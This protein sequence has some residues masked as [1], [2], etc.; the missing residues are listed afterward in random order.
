MQIQLGSDYTLIWRGVTVWL[1]TDGRLWIDLETLN[2][3]DAAQI[4]TIATIKTYRQAIA[5]SYRLAEMSNDCDMAVE[6]L[7][8]YSGGT[9][10]HSVRDFLNRYKDADGVRDFVLS[11]LDL[12]W[13]EV[14]WELPPDA[15]SLADRIVDTVKKLRKYQRMWEMQEVAEKYA[16]EHRGFVYLFKLSTGHYK[17]GLSK[18][19][20][21]RGREITSGLPFTLEL[22][23]QIPSNQI[24][25][26]EETLHQRFSHQ[27]Y[28]STEWFTLTDD[29]LGYI[30]SLGEQNYEWVANQEWTAF[31]QMIAE[32]KAKD[33]QESLQRCKSMPGGWPFFQKPSRTKATPSDIE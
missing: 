14:F 3:E 27:R 29:D 23:H 9:W 5:A 17:I 8:K 15:P 2:F 11:L 12:A 16:N 26:L 32:R 21:R 33:H 7:E 28:A 25:Y 13:G 1:N 18:N 22:I 6:V 10:D 4:E 24:T 31:Y 19:P 20:Q 30:C